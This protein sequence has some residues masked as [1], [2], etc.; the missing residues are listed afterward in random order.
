MSRDREATGTS[1]VS[2][3]TGAMGLDLGFEQEGFEVK[4]AVEQ[5]RPAVDTIKANRPSIP[6]I[7]RD[8]CDVTTEAILERAS[9]NVGEITVVT[10]APPCEPFSTAGRRQG[11][12]DGRAVGVYEFIRVVKEAKP[13]F[14]VFEQVPGFLRAAKRHISFYERVKRRPEELDPDER[15][16]SAFE[17]MIAAFSETGYALSYDPD[18]PRGSIL[19]A[20]DFGVAQNRRRFI[21][22]G[23]RDGSP[24]GLPS[25]SHG[26][27]ASL[28]VANGSRLPW[29]TLKE[30]LNGLYDPQPECLQFPSS[31][32]HLL[33]LV[34]AG[35]CWRALPPELH[36]EALGGAYD[37]DGQGLKGGRTGFLRRLAW[38]RPSP[39][40]VD[41]PTTRAGCLCH[42]E[43]LRPLSVKEYSKL[44]SFPDDWV[45]RGSLLARY[46]L[47]G[48]ATPVLL[49]RAIAKAVKAG[50]YAGGK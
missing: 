20:A 37:S 22:I 3:F 16:G 48:Q 49:A 25:P 29:R 42:P 31:W 35:G 13:R 46:R 32:R 10:G 40:L 11:L 7:D 23:A 38:D 27:P 33:A 17:E 15:L 28:E 21:L 4:V 47:A 30:E 5:E 19:N 2:L 12:Q 18:H 41:R 36:E 24:I 6:V 45:F 1:V 14:F 43:E 8:I 39:T 34:P 50:L 44:Q 26:D 9:L